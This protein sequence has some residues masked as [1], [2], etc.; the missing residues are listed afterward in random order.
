MFLSGLPGDTYFATAG[1]LDL[2]IIVLTANL[3]TTTGLVAEFHRICGASIIFNAA[4]W[5]TWRHYI[6][7]TGYALAYVLLYS[8]TILV[9]VKD[10]GI[11]EKKYLTFRQ[12]TI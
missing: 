7:L 1:L 11:P 6:D 8:W 3:V 12:Y 4:G 9:L 10:E 5:I 2:F